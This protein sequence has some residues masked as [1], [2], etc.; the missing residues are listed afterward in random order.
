[1]HGLKWVNLKKQIIPFD[2]NNNSVAPEHVNLKFIKCNHLTPIGGI[3]SCFAFRWASLSLTHS[4]NDHNPQKAVFC[5]S[6]W[7]VPKSE[8]KFIKRFFFIILYQFNPCLRAPGLMGVSQSI[9]H[10]VHLANSIN[11]H[12]KKKAMTLCVWKEVHTIEADN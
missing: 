2:S 8:L 3:F 11:S 6:M 9:S 7:C 10:Q 1:M 4:L 5:F 12:F